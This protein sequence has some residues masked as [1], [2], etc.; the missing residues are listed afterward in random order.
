MHV[1]AFC[2]ILPLLIAF[3]FSHP[4]ALLT[5]EKGKDK[6]R[7]NPHVSAP[8]TTDWLEGTAPQAEEE[9]A[10]VYECSPTP[11][12]VNSEDAEGLL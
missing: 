3:N 8:W 12:H 7:A 2:R 9:R 11:V 6:I 4:L 10:R 1:S 5:A